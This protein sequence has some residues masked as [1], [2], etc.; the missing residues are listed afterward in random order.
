VKHPRGDLFIDAGFGRHVDEQFRT[1]PFMVRARTFYRLW[2][3]AADQLRD[4]GYDLKSLYAIL[5]TH[6]H[7]DHVGGLP[8][9]PGVPVRVTPPEHEFI[10]KSGDMN[11]CRL[12]T[13]IRYEVYGFEGGPLPRLCFQPR[14]RSHSRQCHHVRGVTQRNALRLCWGP[15]LAV[16]RNHG[17]RG[18]PLDQPQK[19]PIQMPRA[20]VKTCCA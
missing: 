19:G 16:G 6:S 15:R 4:V 9:Y 7:S 1:L 3:P 20:T 14:H 11:F 17:A 8:D 10:R 5:L 18:A 13:G 12:F 2:R